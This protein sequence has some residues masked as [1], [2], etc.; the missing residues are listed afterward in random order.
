MSLE[1]DPLHSHDLLHSGQGWLTS[2]TQTN[3]ALSAG[4]S[5]LPAQTDL[6]GSLYWWPSPSPSP[7]TRY[8]PHQKHTTADQKSKNISTKVCTSKYRFAWLP[9]K[10]LMPL[11]L[12]PTGLWRLLVTAGIREP[13]GSSLPNAVRCHQPR[14]P[15]LEPPGP[16][17]SAAR[18]LR[19]GQS[20]GGKILPT[21]AYRL[22]NPL[23]PIG[24]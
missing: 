19:L 4:S 3:R 5:E 22:Q 15:Q 8:L 11:T 1:L 12:A 13:Q 18:T 17:S 20:T 23:Q 16:E 7:G 2:Q 14:M 9:H 24:K 10:L 6:Q 21:S